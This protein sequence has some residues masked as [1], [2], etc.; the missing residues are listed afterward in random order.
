MSIRQERMESCV[1]V[2]EFSSLEEFLGNMSA[3]EVVSTIPMDKDPDEGSDDVFSDK[4]SEGKHKKR[5]RTDVEIV[6]PV[7]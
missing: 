3:E 4:K 1:S 2:T 7:K 5:E 6:S